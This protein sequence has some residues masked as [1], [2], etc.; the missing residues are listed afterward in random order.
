MCS[1]LSK[2]GWRRLLTSHIHPGCN[3]SHE[4]THLAGTGIKLFAIALRGDDVI[5]IYLLE[6]LWLNFF[7]HLIRSQFLL[8]GGENW[9]WCSLYTVANKLIY[10]RMFKRRPQHSLCVIQDTWAT[11]SDDDRQNRRRCILMSTREVYT[12]WREKDWSDWGNSRSV[13]SSLGSVLVS[14]I[15]GIS[16]LREDEIFSSNS[17]SCW[18]C[19]LV[20]I[21]PSVFVGL[22][23]ELLQHS[24]SGEISR[25]L[26]CS[27]H[28]SP[29][30]ICMYISTRSRER[31]ARLSICETEKVLRCC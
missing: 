31:I 10:Y 7:R 26:I 9:V 30:L 17:F 1:D 18:K 19:C 13:W 24:M 29:F 8:N 15:N 14:V 20:S 28:Y 5:K 27:P 3:P 12:K 6:E 4:H 2:K 16:S 11:W 23:P 22:T 21:S 25:W